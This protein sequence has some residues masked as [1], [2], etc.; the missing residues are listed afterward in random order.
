M[1]IGWKESRTFFAREESSSMYQEKLNF[2]TVATRSC[3]TTSISAIVWKQKKK[4]ILKNDCAQHNELGVSFVGQVW[5]TWV[6][7]FFL[8]WAF[9]FFF[10]RP[11]GFGEKKVTRNIEKKAHGLIVILLLVSRLKLL[12]G[13]HMRSSCRFT[14]NMPQGSAP[15]HPFS[16]ENKPVTTNAGKT[17]VIIDH[18][19]SFS[20]AC[21]GAGRKQR[22]RKNNQERIIMHVPKWKT[23]R[24]CVCLYTRVPD[25][26]VEIFAGT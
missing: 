24:S 20:W 26:L 3:L 11:R 19:T 6:S 23:S 12:H 5:N 18:Q 9:C 7:A 1:S 21:D 17:P 25:V 4:K 16:S 2:R 10:A 15:V 22:K 8:L 14:R 13:K